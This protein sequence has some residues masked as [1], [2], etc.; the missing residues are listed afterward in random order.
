MAPH[1]AA[2]IETDRDAEGCQYEVRSKGPGGPDNGHSLGGH[3]LTKPTDPAPNVGVPDPE[4]EQVHQGDADL[5]LGAPQRARSL[6]APDILAEQVKVWKKW[7]KA[8]DA[9]PREVNYVAPSDQNH[10]RLWMAP[11]ACRPPLSKGS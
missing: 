8:E 11:Q 7:W 6:A 3:K 9:A 4:A 2:C 5:K 10:I 1:G